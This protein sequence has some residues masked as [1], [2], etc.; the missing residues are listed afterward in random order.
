M[1]ASEGAMAPMVSAVSATSS[2]QLV[3]VVFFEVV[4]VVDPGV[5]LDLIELVAIERCESPQP[6]E[7]AGAASWCGS[8]ERA[9]VAHHPLAC[10]EARDPSPDPPIAIQDVGQFG[11]E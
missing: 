1:P 3:D 5:G 7:G 11:R 9:E 2:R 8:R 4:L 6:A 10:G